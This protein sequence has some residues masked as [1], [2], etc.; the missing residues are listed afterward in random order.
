MRSLATIGSFIILLGL[1]FLYGWVAV[2]LLL[3]AR[4]ETALDFD[5][6]GE[7]ARPEELS[8]YLSLF[9]ADSWVH[10]PETKFQYLRFGDTL[11]FFGKDEAKGRIVKLEPCSILM[12]PGSDEANPSE[13]QFQE[14]LKQA[15]IMQTPAYAEIEFNR[16]F[17]LGQTPLPDIVGG[18]LFGA[19][20]IES[21]GKKA[22][23]EDDVY[24]ETEDVELAMTNPALTKITTVKDVRFR[25]GYHTGEGSILTTELVAS[26]PKLPKSAKELSRVQFETLKRLDLVFPE[27]PGV[28]AQVRLDKTPGVLQ[29][30]RIIPG[31]PVTFMNV[32]CQSSFSFFSQKKDQSW[33]ARFLGNVRISRTA[34]DGLTDLLTGEEVLVDFQAKTNA[35]KSATA[36]DKGQ[37]GIMGDLEPVRFKALGRLAQNNQPP[38]PARVDSKRNGGVQMAGDQILYDM[39][40]NSLAL[41]T[42]AAA[43][44]SPEVE[45]VLE[46]RYTIRGQKGFEYIMDPTGELGKLTS[47]GEGALSG[48]FGE[49]G[50]PRNLFLSWH[51]MQVMP[52]PENKDLMIVK[53][54]DGIAANQEGFGTMTA[55]KLD[56]WCRREQQASAKT[57]AKATPNTPRV[58]GLGAGGRG[59]IKPVVA[60]VS[61]KVHFENESGV[62][63][64]NRMEVTFQDAGET[65]L[66]VVGGVQT[67]WMPP[68]LAPMVVSGR[69][70]NRP[71]S[72][73]WPTRQLTAAP[74]ND[75]IQNDIRLVQHLQPLQKQSPQKT[76]PVPLYE[77]TPNPALT[78]Q[79]R[80]TIVTNTPT[81]TSTT[82]KPTSVAT[83]NLLGL[84]STGSPAKYEITGNVMQLQVRSDELGNSIVDTIRIKDQVKMVETVLDSTQGDLIEVLGD[85][86]RIWNPSTPHTQVLITGTPAQDAEFRGRGARMVAGEINISKPENKIWSRG[87]GR[88]RIDSDKT[89]GVMASKGFG[90]TGDAPL[91]P[92]KPR[93]PPTQPESSPLVVQWNELML[94][95]GER[96]FFRGIPDPHGNRVRAL[97]QDKS[98]WCNKMEIQLNKVVNFF[99]KES[100]TDIPTEAETIRCLHDV[101]ILIQE[102][103]EHGNQ[104]SI[105]EAQFE[106]LSYQ[107]K[108]N[109]FVA[110]ALEP[111]MLQRTFFSSGGGLGETKATHGAVA[112]NFEQKNAGEEALSFLSVWF[113]REMHGTLLPG[114]MD[115][116]IN[117]AVKTVYCPVSSWDDK[118]G[119]DNIKAALRLG[120]I[121]ECE[122]L[123]IVQMP[124]PLNSNQGTLEL[125]AK[126]DAA[127]EG[128]KLFGRAREIRYNQAK[129]LVVFEGNATLHKTENGKRTENSAEAFEYNLD[130]GAVKVRQSSGIIMGP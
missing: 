48:N 39:K 81:S 14:Q 57:P 43:G 12:L 97:F 80:P 123:R 21:A 24:L 106:K 33:I 58:P 32:T 22:G 85:E 115:V 31:G 41:E 120:H 53:M 38:V 45:I 113:E 17:N 52:D 60:V 44:G 28:P 121:L 107:V 77:A 118:I 8:P 35:T 27:D 91:V 78:N 102:K 50:R 84:Q 69:E 95:D 4:A 25:F 96:I 99:E 73:T 67:G 122:T 54:W 2:P 6:H 20:K 72:M 61:D 103:D 34:P 18:R 86:V 40:K 63:N 129:S 130:N 66:A 117:G 105:S 82:S 79:T 10:N 124:D 83:Q 88:I 46:N 110:E 76:Q 104:Q 49:P 59:G 126:E 56:L 11:L 90:S 7:N 36:T 55:G 71:Q 111:G 13:E 65:A 9:P 62:C 116:E 64:V 37:G 75:S 93:T 29:G 47:L 127:I 87:M 108:M 109:F 70:G 98:I 16:D 119:R 23:P 5:R 112:S 114:R 19:V 94:F 89:E 92:L 125:T 3:P 68:P 101:Y 100:E 30:K 15:V 74:T 26:N 42:Q 51:L 1:Y 128:G